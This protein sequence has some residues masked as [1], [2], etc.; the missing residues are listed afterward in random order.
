MSVPHGATLFHSAIAAPSESMPNHVLIVAD[1]NTA[2]P[3]RFSEN[4]YEFL[5]TL[6]ESFTASSDM[7][8]VVRRIVTAAREELHADRGW[9]L[10]PINE[11]AEFT[12]GILSVAAPD[13]EDVAN[14]DNALV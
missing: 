2:S 8:A 9:L 7:K 6:L 11:H 3:P 1:E 4:R 5:A 14:S 10:H 13:V 12:R